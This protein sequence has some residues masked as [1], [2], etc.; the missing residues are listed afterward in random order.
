M[1]AFHAVAVP[2]QD[3]LDGKLTMDVLQLTSGKSA[4]TGDLMNIVMQ[5]GSLIKPIAQ[6]DFQI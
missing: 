4:R 6:K 2:H 1:K 5:R 3:I